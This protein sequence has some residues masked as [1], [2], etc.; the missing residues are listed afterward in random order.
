MISLIPTILSIIDNGIKLWDK[1]RMLAFKKKYHKLLTALSEAENRQHPY[2]ID[3]D[4]D[5]ITERINILIL[6]YD[7]ELKAEILSKEKK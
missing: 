6:A 1:G 7:V 3:A 4:I 2:Y 5:L